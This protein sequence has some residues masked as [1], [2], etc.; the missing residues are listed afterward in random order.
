MEI[1]VVHFRRK[2]CCHRKLNNLSY[3][4]FRM[5]FDEVYGTSSHP[6]SLTTGSRLTSPTCEDLGIPCNI[7]SLYH[8]DSPSLSSPPLHEIPG[9]GVSIPHGLLRPIHGDTIGAQQHI[10]KVNVLSY[11]LSRCLGMLELLHFNKRM[12]SY[13]P[14]LISSIS[15]VCVGFRINRSFKYDDVLCEIVNVSFSL[16][17]GKVVGALSKIPAP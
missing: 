5:S 7:T 2:L 11:F 13:M 16:E 1:H 14:Y 4:L 17:M 15:C 3:L 12:V 6:E 8:R 9:T 10:F